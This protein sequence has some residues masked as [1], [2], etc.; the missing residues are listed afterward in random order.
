MPKDIASRYAEKMNDPMPMYHPFGGSYMKERMT[1]R[2]TGYEVPMSIHV[3]NV[4]YRSVLKK[5]L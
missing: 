5:Y 1:S 4:A 2:K 3:V